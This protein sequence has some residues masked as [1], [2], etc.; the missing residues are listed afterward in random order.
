MMSSRTRS[1]LGSD[2]SRRMLMG[3][4]GLAALFGTTGCSALTQ[5]PFGGQDSGLEVLLRRIGGASITDTSTSPNQV[6]WSRPAGAAEVLGLDSTA[7]L[8]IPGPASWLRALAITDPQIV[9]DALIGRVAVSDSEALDTAE[10]LMTPTETAR[11]W[12]HGNEA[13]VWAG[14]AGMLD[15]LEA[16]L[17][18]YVVREGDQLR[19]AE[20]SDPRASVYTRIV[21]SLGEDL[22]FT[23][24]ETLDGFD[25]EESVAD[26]FVDLGEL[27]S[28]MDLEDPHLV[29]GT[30]FTDVSN[31]GDDAHATAYVFGSRFDS[32]EQCTTRGAVRVE[33]DAGVVAQRLKDEAPPEDDEL[34]GFLR[35]VEAEAD[36]DLVR[37]EISTGSPED[38]LFWQA[39]EQFHRNTPRGMSGS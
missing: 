29:S 25:A 39:P 6:F 3:A 10:R 12:R 14:A 18:P 1:V 21:A 34:T 24:E 15:D 20:G 11:V 33:G 23:T 9:Q 35:V 8:H 38:D 31:F 4:G 16:A 32:A 26:L 5:L 2:L 19:V 28:E 37:V 22:V 36:G 17:G 13:A 30:V 27:V 7:D